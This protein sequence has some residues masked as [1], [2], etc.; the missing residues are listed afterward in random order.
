[1]TFRHFNKPVLNKKNINFFSFLIIFFQNFWTVTYIFV[2]L[3]WLCLQHEFSLYL[4]LCIQQQM[5]ENN[6]E[7]F[8]NNQ[9]WIKLNNEWMNEWMMHLYSAFIVYCHTP[10][11]LYNHV[12]GLSSTTTSI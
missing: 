2:V 4:H 11:A 10:K 7:L 6:Y 12:G 5:F 3:F 9:I 1:M 8:Q